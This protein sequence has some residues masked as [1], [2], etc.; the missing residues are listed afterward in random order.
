MIRH[1]KNKGKLSLK[2]EQPPLTAFPLLNAAHHNPHDI[3]ALLLPELL[4]TNLA[5]ALGFMIHDVV[6]QSVTPPLYWGGDPVVP[7]TAYINCAVHATMIGR[8]FSL[9]SSSTPS[10][11]GKTEDEILAAASELP[12]ELKLLIHAEFMTYQRQRRRLWQHA[13]SPVFVKA[14]LSGR[15]AEP[16]SLFA[17]AIIVLGCWHTIVSASPP[18]KG[19]GKDFVWYDGTFNDV[20]WGPHDLERALHQTSHLPTNNWDVAALKA[21]ERN[22][23]SLPPEYVPLECIKVLDR[24]RLHANTG[25]PDLTSAEII[26]LVFQVLDHSKS[27]QD[28]SQWVVKATESWK[29]KVKNSW[30]TP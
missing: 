17:A 30:Q 23:G 10:A 13:V 8:T 20:S 27:P 6:T 25:G 26:D 12:P 4:D 21:N 24:A 18:V 16:G 14:L 28:H 11:D 9:L 5:P 29:D 19:R 1:P 7:M 2:I 22:W 15:E 3:D